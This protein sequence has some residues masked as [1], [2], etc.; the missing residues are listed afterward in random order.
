MVSR[1]FT[2]TGPGS[3]HRG[4]GTVG[5]V[6]TLALIAYGVFVAIQYVP[7]H[8][9]WVTVSDVLDKVAETHRQRRFNGTEAVWATID[10][11]LYVN[12]RGD[13]K[14]VFTVAP[15]PNAGYLVTARYQRPLNL[16]F[17]E[18]QVDHEKSIELR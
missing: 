1:Q 13:L 14:E 17:T 16:L 10:R 5:L 3:A 15:A 11:Q 9:E 4:A 7:Q 2:P 12:E 18:K 8:I 6:V